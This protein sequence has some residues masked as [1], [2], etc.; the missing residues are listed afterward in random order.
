MTGPM[1]H[2]LLALMQPALKPGRA[3]SV[4]ALT[5]YG[6][7]R[8]QPSARKSHLA[9]LEVC[10][11]G[12]ERIGLQKAGRKIRYTKEWPSSSVSACRH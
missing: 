10:L 9:W 11:R 5:T 4:R 12:S 8:H 7:S 3:L 6:A 1:S 2:W